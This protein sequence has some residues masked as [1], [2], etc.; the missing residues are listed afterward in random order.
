MNNSRLEHL[1][2]FYQDQPNDPFN[3]Y[4]LAN[5]Y[6]LANPEKALGYFELLIRN[7]PDYL[8][9]YY[10]LAQLYI[11]LDK[12]EKAKKTFEDGIQ[13]AAIVDDQLALRELKNA[14]EEFVM[15]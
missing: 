5:E 3:I 10:H 14:Y 11:D 7:H 9:T 4:A 13:K 12:P 6:K 1:L 15:E 8:A 2:K